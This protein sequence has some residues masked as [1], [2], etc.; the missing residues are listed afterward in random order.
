MKRKVAFKKVGR[1]SKE[2]AEFI[3]KFYTEVLN[4]R[5]GAN[6]EELLED[7][8]RPPKRKQR[9]TNIFWECD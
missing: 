3:E 9:K 6:F 2:T 1:N 5:N 8:N 7:A 4:R